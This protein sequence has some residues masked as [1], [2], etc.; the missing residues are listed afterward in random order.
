[1]GIAEAAQIFTSGRDRRARRRQEGM[2]N[3]WSQVRNTAN[4]FAGQRE[5]DKGR[6]FTEG[7][8]TLD[9]EANEDIEKLRLKG[10]M[11]LEDLRH[12]HALKQDLE[13][14]N[15]AQNE[16]L[17]RF[18]SELG[19]DNEEE[20]WE[21][22]FINQL[23]LVSSGRNENESEMAR[24]LRMGRMSIES[25][26]EFRENGATAENRDRLIDHMVSVTRQE[27]S[28]GDPALI[29][30][31]V[32]DYVD[33]LIGEAVGEKVDV[34]DTPKGG[35]FPVRLPRIVPGEEA[36]HQKIIDAVRALR[37]E[38]REGRTAET[39]R[40]DSDLSKAMGLINKE[41]LISQ[42]HRS[43]I[44]RL[45]GL[46]E[47]AVIAGRGVGSAVATGAEA[48]APTATVAEVDHPPIVLS[49]REEDRAV[50]GVYAPALAAEGLK[51]ESEEVQR[52][53]EL[54]R[55]GDATPEDIQ[56]ILRLAERRNNQV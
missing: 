35:L 10:D 7:Q 2:N 41:G 5:A 31:M 27:F 54:Y 43:A 32:E 17:R 19:A 33:T 28:T 12:G 22:H 34:E 36:L 9:R 53:Q 1:M 45:L 3:L 11:K 30:E 47:D 38:Q 18:G 15:N 24:A 4:I 16:I 52:I 40:R 39:M 8:A 56:W 13:R 20:A 42:R 37:I 26:A 29:R 50:L 49:K 55:M 14:T 48:V 25:F 21:K 6:L 46:S 51:Q 23:K 44:E